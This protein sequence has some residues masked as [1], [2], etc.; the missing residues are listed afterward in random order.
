M[1][2]KT[3][4]PSVYSFLTDEPPAEK[5]RTILLEE[6]KEGDDSFNMKQASLPPGKLPCSATELL[7]GSSSC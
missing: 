3:E 5:L 2:E 7:A 6:F 1:D 4:D